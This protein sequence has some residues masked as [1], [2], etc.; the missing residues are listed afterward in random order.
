MKVRGKLQRYYDKDNNISIS[1]NIVLLDDTILC[2]GDIYKKDDIKNN[3]TIYTHLTDVLTVG[4][5]FYNKEDVMN[6]SALEIFY[7]ADHIKL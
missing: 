6:F 3:H 1:L 2:Q 4:V 5:K 7:L